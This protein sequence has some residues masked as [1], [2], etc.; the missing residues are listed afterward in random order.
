MYIPP[1]KSSESSS[2]SD[3]NRNDRPK[4]E[5]KQ[6]S[7]LGEVVRKQTDL[8]APMLS[9]SR[10]KLKSE[11]TN[12]SRKQQE[13]FKI[14]ISPYAPLDSHSSVALEFENPLSDDS[15]IKLEHIETQDDVNPKTSDNIIAE[16]YKSSGNPRSR[17][18]LGRLIPQRLHITS[19]QP[20]IKINNVDKKAFKEAKKIATDLFLISLSKDDENYL[21]MECSQLPKGGNIQDMNKSTP[22]QK[23]VWDFYVDASIKKKYHPENIDPKTIS[24]LI[25]Y[26]TD[27]RNEYM[28]PK[29]SKKEITDDDRK[30]VNIAVDTLAAWWQLDC[31]GHKHEVD[32]LEPS[33]TCRIADEALGEALELF[34]K[35]CSKEINKIGQDNKND[36]RGLPI[37]FFSSK[38][39][40]TEYFKR[41]FA[42]ELT[43]LSK[44]LIDLVD[45]CLQELDIR[46]FELIAF[47]ESYLNADKAIE[48]DGLIQTLLTG[49]S[50]WAATA[51]IP[52]TTGK[53]LSGL[54][55]QINSAELSDEIKSSAKYE[56][57]YQLFMV[58]MIE[59]VVHHLAPLRVKRGS[60]RIKAALECATKEVASRQDATRTESPK[61]FDYLKGGGQSL[62][63]MIKLLETPHLG[64]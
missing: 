64:S 61:V 39:N 36:E 44:Q 24:K 16:N 11:R 59:A 57:I 52:P 60:D 31:A 17:K 49:I 41:L 18:W 12:R 7:K 33:D 13:V 5:K 55:A 63:K 43:S 15:Y 51:A 37:Y 20:K 50:E 4:F 54:L 1:R 29:K 21:A 53:A 30:Q 9:N 45:S 56:A 62:R 47:N 28:N 8:P 25:D 26:L 40:A 23:L 10:R 27:M 46:C 2:S 48:W 3:K 38:T 14:N 32:L 42:P 6:P 19:D 58:P 34:H 22:I 35:E